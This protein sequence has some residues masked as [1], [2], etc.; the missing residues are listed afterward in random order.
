MKALDGLMTEKK[1]HCIVW[2]LNA[3]FF[4]APSGI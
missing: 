4:T 3:D 2:G 1:T